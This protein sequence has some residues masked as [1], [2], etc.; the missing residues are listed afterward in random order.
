MAITTVPKLF[1]GLASGLTQG[2][3]RLYSVTLGLLQDWTAVSLTAF[4]TGVYQA[5][6]PLPYGFVQGY[7]VSRAPG[8]STTESYPEEIGTG[9]FV[10]SLPSA[11][12][13]TG[14]NNVGVALA[15][16]RR[17]YIYKYG[18]S[19]TV[20]GTPYRMQTQPDP[21][22]PG[23][24]LPS[25]VLNAAAADLRLFTAAPADFPV[26]MAS[27]TALVW[28]GV[29]Y[30]VLLSTYQEMSAVPNRLKIRTYR[31]PQADIA[32]AETTAEAVASGIPANAGLR[33]EYLPAKP[34]F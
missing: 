17:A 6:I 27:G 1:N 7:I 23:A 18:V 9:V 28:E 29:S 3:F 5:Q 10:P 2:E 15:R 32:T 24:L 16:Q 26:P 12:V 33:K 14:L 13:L 21:V 22:A 30:T 19:V 8:D 31:T 25:G 4:G 34:P 11:P 20:G